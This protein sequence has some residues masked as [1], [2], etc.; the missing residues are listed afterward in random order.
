MSGVEFDKVIQELN[1]RFAAPLPEFYKRRIIVWI[2]AEQEFMDKL[3]D[4]TVS[5][6]KVVALT[7]SN[8]FYV[9]KLLAVDDPASNYLVY[10]PFAYES[11][12]DNW[13]LDI[14]LYGEEFRA[15]L[16]SIWMDEMG[17]PQNTKGE[18]YQYEVYWSSVPDGVD[19]SEKALTRGSSWWMRSFGN[20]RY[21]FVGPH[22]EIKQ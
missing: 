18:G 11:D 6:A 7:G 22:G 12:E 15:D 17:V 13:M 19:N 8:N 16:V 4:I 14:E 3:D 21:H 5:G 9:K 10:R 2:D 1:R 20:N